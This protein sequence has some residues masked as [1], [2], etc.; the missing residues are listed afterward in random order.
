MLRWFA[1]VAMVLIG[2]LPTS[3]EEMPKVD[4]LAIAMIE[5]NRG[6]GLPE[7]GLRIRECNSGAQATCQYTA[8][9]ELA[10]IVA[11]PTQVSELESIVLIGAAGMSVPHLFGG[12]AN[13]ITIMEP[14]I[15]A[16][17]RGAIVAQ[18]S[19]AEVDGETQRT[20]TDR[21]RYSMSMS[22]VTGLWFTAELKD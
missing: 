1:A 19:G 4:E 2:S 6:T 22:S 15:T 14:G 11:G 5:A 3:A 17:G 12:M 16:D 7:P 18:L 10:Y 20:E 21:A 9:G 8:A 13:V